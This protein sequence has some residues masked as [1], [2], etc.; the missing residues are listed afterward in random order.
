MREISSDMTQFV[1]NSKQTVG[2]DPCG[3][4][5]SQVGKPPDYKTWH[6]QII[7]SK[8]TGPCHPA[9]LNP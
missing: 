6:V 1:Y 4:D 8:Q 2:Q 5:E 9:K 7:T 3:P